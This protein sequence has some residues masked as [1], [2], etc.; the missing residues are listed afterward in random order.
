MNLIHIVGRKNNG[1]TKLIVELIR[2]MQHRGFRVGAIK[3]SGHA[4]ELDTPGKDSYHH[5]MAGAEPVAVIA[6]DQSAVYLP[7]RENVHPMDVIAPLFAETD[8]VLVE[9][10]IEGPGK[11]IEVWRKEMGSSPIFY[12]R[13]DIMAVITDDSI[14]TALP[15]WPRNDVPKIIAGICRLAALEVSGKHR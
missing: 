14:H 2:E 11:K 12:E 3:H 6:R 15:I 1:K 9:G 8:L 13:N 5:R 7:R 4:H 10:F